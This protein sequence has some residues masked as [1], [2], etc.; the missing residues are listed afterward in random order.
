MPVRRRIGR[1]AALAAK[2]DRM[3]VLDRRRPLNWA[4]PPPP[5]GPQ[6]KLRSLLIFTLVVALALGYVRAVGVDTRRMA[7][8]V[9]VLMPSMAILVAALLAIGRDIWAM[10]WRQR[11]LHAGL[12]L[13]AFGVVGFLVWFSV[14]FTGP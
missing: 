14:R 9:P 7:V 3:G 4:P 5:P 11:L 1:D 6:F 2:V 10:T 12:L 13:G 8:Y